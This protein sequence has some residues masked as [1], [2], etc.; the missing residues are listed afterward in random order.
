MPT[1]TLPA[2]TRR[3]TALA[4]AVLTVAAATGAVA[5]GSPG[6][7]PDQHHDRLVAACRATL[8]QQISTTV[9]WPGDET[10]APWNRT[11]EQDSLWRRVDGT[12]QADRPGRWICTAQWTGAR[13]QIGT[14]QLT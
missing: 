10:V 7:G 8:A 3:R 9:S 5:V 2:T 12:Y 6:D 1:A 13:W 11:D 14:A 4:A